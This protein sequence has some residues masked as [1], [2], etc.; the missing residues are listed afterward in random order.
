VQESKIYLQFILPNWAFV[1]TSIYSISKAVM[2]TDE[3]RILLER[4]VLFRDIDLKEIDG[5]L[6]D[7]FVISVFSGEKLLEIGQKNTSLYLILD[8]EL[9]VYLD[10]RDLTEHAV[11]GAGECVGELSLIDGGSASALVIAAQ[12]TRVLVVPHLHVWSLVDNSHGVARNLLSVLAGRIRNDNLMRV[13]ADER[14]LEFE[15]SS[16]VDGLTGLHNRLWM[17]DA[18]PRMML[19]CERNEVP[20]CLLMTDVDHFDGFNHNFGRKVG[21]GVLKLV[22]KLMAENLRP[23]DLLV[24]LGTDK[25]AI[26]LPETTD[27]G[28]LNIA[29]RLREVMALSTLGSGATDPAHTGKPTH[30]YSETG[31]TISIGIAAMQAGD[32]LESILSMAHMALLQAKA[33]GRNQVKVATFQAAV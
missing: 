11:M 30:L 31:I 10:S 24:Y 2:M 28:A 19:R 3:E 7:C 33:A 18:F 15:V 6:G 27:K 29:E 26:L 23:Q 8:G 16:N 17:D 25:F 22:A 14:S 21:D 20:L 9:H 4:N 5:I 32:T 1:Y 13:T 12:D